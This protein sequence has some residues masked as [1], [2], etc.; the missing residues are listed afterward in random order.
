MDHPRKNFISMPAPTKK[1]DFS[2]DK[3]LESFKSKLSS[4]PQEDL[5]EDDENEEINKEDILREILEVI[6]SSN[7]SLLSWLS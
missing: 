3:I 6:S 2:A 7:N 5:E 1:P 4:A